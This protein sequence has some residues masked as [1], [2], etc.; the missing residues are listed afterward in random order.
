M[1]R[2]MRAWV[3]CR[4]LVLVVL[5][6]T[7]CRPYS[8]LGIRTLR[9]SDFL[10]SG[11]RRWEILYAERN[12]VWI[13]FVILVVCVV[14]ERF[15]SSS[16]PRYLNS[17]T[18][19]TCIPNGSE[20]SG[21]MVTFL[22]LLWVPKSLAAIWSNYGMLGLVSPMLGQDY[23]KFGLWMLTKQSLGQICGAEGQNFN[24]DPCDLCTIN[25]LSPWGT[26]WRLVGWHSIIYLSLVEDF[27]LGQQ[28]KVEKRDSSLST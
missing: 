21:W 28:Y 1:K 16:S 13:L 19:G 25:G 14:R 27:M 15:W 5:V 20:I 7:S 22:S 6:A 4:S 9:A 2:R 12:W 26:S 18:T 23:I 10:D 8:V 11:V 24:C 3:F 17:V